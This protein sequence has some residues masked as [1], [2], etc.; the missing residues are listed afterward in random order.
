MKYAVCITPCPIQ[1]TQENFL[2]VEVH[3]ESEEEATKKAW[4]K[5]R[6]AHDGFEPWFNF[7]KSGDDAED[8]LKECRDGRKALM[9]TEGEKK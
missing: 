5:I 1:R 9:N 6:W 3:A 2:V 7:V 4:E 8:Y